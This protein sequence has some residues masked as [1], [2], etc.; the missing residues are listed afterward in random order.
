MKWTPIDPT[1]HDVIVVAGQSNGASLLWWG[2][3][4]FA[5][6]AVSGS[7]MASWAKGDASGRYATIT[8]YITAQTT[9]RRAVL[10]WVHGEYDAQAEVDAN[11]YE[12]AFGAFIDNLV[13]DLSS[14]AFRCVVSYINGNGTRTYVSTVRTAQET[15]VAAR[16]YMV[17]VDNDDLSLTDGVHYDVADV[18]TRRDRMDAAKDTI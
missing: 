11:A 16:A 15:V 14:Y 17:G 10:Y 13:S 18:N 6:V 1:E 8:D 4:R 9:D 12:S 2:H 7:S 3:P 5:N